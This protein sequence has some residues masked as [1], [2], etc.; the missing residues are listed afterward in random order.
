MVES[1]AMWTLW[2]K[3]RAWLQV[4][5]EGCDGQSVMRRTHVGITHQSLV[6]LWAPTP[7]MDVNYESLS[8]CDD[9]GDGE[10][11]DGLPYSSGHPVE[12]VF[13][14]FWEQ[15]EDSPA[16]PPEAFGLSGN[17]YGMRNEAPSFDL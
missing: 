9:E 1:S 12:P 7:A 3:D 13:G 15:S 5:P 14:I 2:D 17:M 4:E 11:S 10:Q 8:E 6:F 16:V